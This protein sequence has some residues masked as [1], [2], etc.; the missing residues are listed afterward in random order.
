MLLTVSLLVLLYVFV[1]L[2]AAQFFM[3]EGPVRD[4]DKTIGAVIIAASVM[5]IFARITTF[6][7]HPSEVEADSTAI[8]LWVGFG[9]FNAML[10]LGLLHRMTVS[11]SDACQSAP[12]SAVEPVKK[13]KYRTAA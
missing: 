4:D 2:R 13:D 11:R 7:N 10:Y 5:F 1:I 8:A 9:L 6:V 12:L 3:M